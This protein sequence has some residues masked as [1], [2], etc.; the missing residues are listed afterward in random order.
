M[1]RHVATQRVWMMCPPP[2]CCRETQMGWRKGA[3]RAHTPPPCALLRLNCAPRC[4]AVFHS[5][6]SSTSSSAAVSCCFC[7]APFHEKA[8]PCRGGWGKRDARTA[9]GGGLG[10]GAW[11]P[12]FRVP[13]SP[14]SPASS[15]LPPF[16]EVPLG[17]LRAIS[18]R[19]GSA[20]GWVGSTT[21]T[22]ADWLLSGRPGGF[23]L[24]Q[25]L[26]DHLVAFA[27]TAMD[28]HG[29]STA[30][31]VEAAYAVTSSLDAS[32][33][34]GRATRDDVSIAEE[35]GGGSANG[36]GDGDGSGDR[37]RMMVVWS[38]VCIVILA[39]GM[40]AV[41]AALLDVWTV[42]ILPV[43]ILANVFREL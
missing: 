2:Q 40:S 8:K 20:K 15:S 9:K 37:G 30:W 25:S 4:A 43:H 5:C 38:G 11:F 21:A 23:K 27:T 18:L 41:L 14:W 3:R 7:G 19:I 26:T 6:L 22:L 33:L 31:V 29:L 1:R 24:N 36:S 32:L 16:E 34:G 35:A 28:V 42:L 13:R 10:E 17:L 12:P 39:G